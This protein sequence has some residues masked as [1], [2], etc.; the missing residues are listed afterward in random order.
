M[1]ITH[2]DGPARYCPDCLKIVDTPQSDT[3]WREEFDELF[4]FDGV[5]YK[6]QRHWKKGVKENLVKS[7]IS[8]LL[9]AEK[10][11]WRS[12]VEGMKL[13]EENDDYDGGYNHALDAVL[14]KLS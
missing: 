2:K 6:G 10:K 9:E 7:F 14:Q 5:W 4:E 13:L 8:Q 1:H 11:R 3:D 12:E